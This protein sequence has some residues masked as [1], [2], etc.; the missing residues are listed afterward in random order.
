MTKSLL[1]MII[2]AGLSMPRPLAAYADVTYTFSCP[3]SSINGAISYSVI[4]MYRSIFKECS[5]KIVYDTRHKQFKSVE[6]SIITASI[7]SSCKWC[8]DIVRSEKALNAAAFPAITFKS[9]DFENKED[10]FWVLGAFDLHGI[11][12]NLRSRFD[13]KEENNHTLFIK[14]MWKFNRKNFNI[15]WNKF[16]DHGG[17]L[18]GDYFTVDWQVK[19]HKI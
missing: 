13:F 9:A 10:G 4:G 8:D 7:K 5:G 3:E 11:T 6:L 17:I 12:K 1:A 15:I 19:A 18:V 14:G 16:L 2:L